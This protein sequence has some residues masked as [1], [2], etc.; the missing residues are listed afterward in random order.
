M[1]QRAVGQQDVSPAANG[2]IQGMLPP[3]E[4][5]SQLAL[6]QGKSLQRDRTQSVNGSCA[7]T[8]HLTRVRVLS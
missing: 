7:Y 3:P 5:G 6:N 1:G 2:I 4:K 8:D